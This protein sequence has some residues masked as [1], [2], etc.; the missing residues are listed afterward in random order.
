MDSIRFKSEK[1]NELTFSKEL[2]K[3]VR[4]YFKENNLSKYGGFSMVFKSLVMLSLYFTPFIIILTVDLQPWFALLL[5][6]LMGIG[7]AGI[8]MSVMHDA[9]HGA[10]SKKGWVNTLAASSMF[11]LGSNTINWKIQHNVSH[12]SYT[13]I[14]GYDPD[15]ST[16]AVIRLCEHAPLK[17]YQRFQ[18]YYAF[19]LYGFMTVLKLFGEI[20]TLIGYNKEG[21]TEQ[22]GANPKLELFKLILTKIVYLGIF[23][24]LPLIFT[25]FSIWQILLGFFIMHLVAGIIMSTVF[26]MAHVVM[27]VYQPLPEDGVIHCDRLVHQLQSSSDFGK[28][29]GLLSWYIGGLDFQVEHHLF[30]TVCHVHYAALAPIVEKTAKEFGL[31]YN[32]NRTFAHALVSH[33]KRLKDLG[34]A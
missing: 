13:N 31:V 33:F 26:Q 28:K 8:G 19:L 17:K 7:E 23:F 21:A 14:Y 24:S 30:P 27:G 2:K 11:L 9:A 6:V 1:L 3:R 32:S 18:Q 22:M 25:D 15:I 12:H 16:K 10:Y 4:E 20:G 34:K 29:S 5:V